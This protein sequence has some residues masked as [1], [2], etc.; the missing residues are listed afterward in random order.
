MNQLKELFCLI[1]GKKLTG[2]QQK[3]CSINHKKKNRERRKWKKINAK[4]KANKLKKKIY[5][6]K[7]I[8]ERLEADKNASS[9]KR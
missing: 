4:T 7:L 6:E 3:Y 5:R 2:K 9:D 1:Y 8:K